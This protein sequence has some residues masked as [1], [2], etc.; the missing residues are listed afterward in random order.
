MKISKTARKKALGFFGAFMSILT[1][2]L[3]LYKVFVSDS[4]VSIAHFVILLLS[5]IIAC[6][7][8]EKEK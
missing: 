5:L 3:I 6:N 1:A 7:G 4:G 8:L 2:L